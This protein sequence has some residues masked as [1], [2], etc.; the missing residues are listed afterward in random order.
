MISPVRHLFHVCTYFVSWLWFGL[1]G[2]ALNAVCAF[3]L[4]LPHRNSLSAHARAAI[5]WL[6]SWWLKW[7][8]ATGALRVAWHN[9]P[10]APLPSGVVY[11]ANHPSL[12]DAPVLLSVLTDCICIFKPALQRN[13]CIAPAAILAG[14]SSGD[15]GIDLIRDVAEKVAAG[16]SLLIFPEGTRTTPGHHLDRLKPGF[17]LI[18]QRAGAPIRLI[19]LKATPRLVARG[20][21][22]WKP[23]CFPARLEVRLHEEILPEIGKS[24][25]EITAYVQDRLAS[26]APVVPASGDSC[27]PP[28]PTSC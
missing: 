9:F 18:A 3:L 26:L 23:P 1:G 4:L 15:S 16:R 2:L 27:R 7:C 12:I 14:Y 25:A 6:F 19:T 21:P 5:R 24:A 13:P 11:I 22:W 8:H 28:G 10:P 20:V 17:A